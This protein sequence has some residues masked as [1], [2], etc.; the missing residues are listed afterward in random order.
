LREERTVLRKTFVL[1]GL[2]VLLSLLFP[3]QA[4]LQE[5]GVD[6]RGLR[7]PLADLAAA[8]VLVAL[9]PAFAMFHDARLARRISRWNPWLVLLGLCSVL[10]VLLHV[11]WS[12][13]LL[14]AYAREA[15]ASALSASSISHLTVVGGVELAA[16]LGVLVS[17]VGVLMH[18]DA[19]PDDDAPPPSPSPKRRKK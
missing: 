15:L 19:M 16:R 17:A 18:L 6:P 12:L 14:T 10:F 3:V 11:N 1:L 7:L 2:A 9:L 13:D 8:C 5:S 4:L